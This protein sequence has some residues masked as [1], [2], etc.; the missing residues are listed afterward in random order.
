MSSYWWLYRWYKTDYLWWLTGTCLL[1]D[2][3]LCHIQCCKQSSVICCI[4]SWLTDCYKWASETDSVY[5]C[6]YTVII[7]GTMNYCFVK[8]TY[9]YLYHDTCIH[10][11][12]TNV[13]MMAE[14]QLLYHIAYVI[15]SSGWLISEALTLLGLFTHISC[16]ISDLDV[17]W[18]YV[19]CS[20]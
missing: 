17:Y 9:L 10:N 4:T 8:C 14:R 1:C 6:R 13:R 11:T 20:Y 18:I 15:R 5:I 16:W 7:T 19:H 3:M 2:I 12:H